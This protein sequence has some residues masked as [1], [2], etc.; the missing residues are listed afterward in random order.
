MVKTHPVDDKKG[1]SALVFWGAALAISVGLILSVLSCMELCVEHCSANENYRLFGLPFA[2]IGTPFFIFILLTHLFS[3]RYPLL[4][5]WTGLMIVAALGAETVFLYVQQYQIGRFCPVCL[6]IFFSL[7]VAW[8]LY[9]GNYVKSLVST[10][11]TGNRGDV[12]KKLLEGLT[13]IP[14]FVL[15]LLLALMGVTKFNPIEAAESDESG[16]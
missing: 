14:F 5:K 2:F 16:G 6:S 10:I 13:S 4:S 1:S 8:L 7:L 15:G 12:M 11:Q 3:R 9:Y